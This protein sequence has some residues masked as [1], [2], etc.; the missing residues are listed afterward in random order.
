MPPDVS[1]YEALRL[2]NM[3]A[4]SQFLESSGIPQMKPTVIASK[5][6]GKFFI[7]R[8]HLI[9]SSFVFIFL[10]YV[11]IQVHQSRDLNHYLCAYFH[12]MP[13]RGQVC[14]GNR[15]IDVLIS[16]LTD[17]AL[18]YMSGCYD[19]LFCCSVY[20][21]TIT[22]YCCILDYN[23]KPVSPASRLGVT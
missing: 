11:V 16:L 18:M 2:H 6:K 12:H 20:P 4:S 19:V 13:S 15:F 5:S 3:A 7:Q 1:E 21:I 9:F 14:Q 17:V 8:R 10:F 22:V 23:I